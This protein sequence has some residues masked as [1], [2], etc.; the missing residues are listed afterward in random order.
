ML[1]PGGRSHH[2]YHAKATNNNNAVTT[3]G[4]GGDCYANNPSNS[5]SNSNV[6][7]VSV[8]NST[9]NRQTP[10]LVSALKTRTNQSQLVV[11]NELVGYKSETTMSSDSGCGQDATLLAPQKQQQQQQ[12]LSTSSRAVETHHKTV[13]IAHERITPEEQPSELVQAV[14]NAMRTVPERN[15][16]NATTTTE[17]D[18]DGNFTDGTVVIG[19]VTDVTDDI[20]SNDYDDEEEPEWDDD[21]SDDDDESQGKHNDSDEVNMKYQYIFI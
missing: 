15:E 17:E 14:R 7:A 9:E 6:S 1:P 16:T 2:V 20:S 5:N 12:R 11:I 21:V 3:E 10:A 18:T 8:T 4:A 13:A 19:K